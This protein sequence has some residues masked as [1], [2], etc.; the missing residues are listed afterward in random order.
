MCHRL[1]CEA[2]TPLCLD[3]RVCASLPE[4]PVKAL[5]RRVRQESCVSRSSLRRLSRLLSS[6]ACRRSVWAIEKSDP[7][8]AAATRCRQPLWHN[9]WSKARPGLCVCAR[10]CGCFVAAA[11]GEG[12][13]DERGF[14]GRQFCWKCVDGS[15]KLSDRNEM[16][17]GA[18]DKVWSWGQLS[19]S[20]FKKKKTNCACPTQHD[21][22]I[23]QWI[24]VSPFWG[25]WQHH[26][27]RMIAFANYL[28]II[29][30]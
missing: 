8:A 7:P 2:P 16:T 20:S 3:L 10:A 9:R 22:F 28:G 12:E 14:G 23:L 26:H 4:G 11:D 17:L 6:S 27:S 13:D 29:H 18:R 25:Y 21:E 30:Y 19:S 24:P 1:L 5:S 15:I